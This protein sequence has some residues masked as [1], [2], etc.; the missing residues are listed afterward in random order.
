M[1][2]IIKIGGLDV[3]KHQDHTAL[4]GLQVYPTENFVFVDYARRW[5]LKT[6]YGTIEYDLAQIQQKAKFDMIGVEINGPGSVL[7]DHLRAKKLPVHPITNTGKITD[8]KKLDDYSK[9]SKPSMAKF[10]LMCKKQH[11]V[12]YPENTKSRYIKELIKQNEMLKQYVTDS[13]N[14]QYKAPGKQHDD[15]TLSFFVA[16]RLAMRYIKIVKPNHFIRRVQA[17]EADPIEQELQVYA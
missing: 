8:L 4:T 9:M 2:R 3:G 15:L 12:K 14:V 7:I 13:G 1:T 11:I 10:L 17:L 16:M 5:N 6:D